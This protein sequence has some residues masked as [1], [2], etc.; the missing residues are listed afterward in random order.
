M[1]LMSR[2]PY[3]GNVGLDCC[4]HKWTW[5]NTAVLAAKADTILREI[6]RN[7]KWQAWN[8]AVTLQGRWGLV[9]MSLDDIKIH[10][11]ST[12]FFFS[13]ATNLVHS[14]SQPWL[15]LDQ[16][17]G[18]LE[19]KFVFCWFVFVYNWSDCL[20]WLN[21]SVRRRGAVRLPSLLLVSSWK[22]EAGCTAHF[23]KMF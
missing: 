2:N 16:L 21:G 13:A 23:Q 10:Q 15:Q 4:V 18:L 3:S 14:V 1:Q 20:C 7:T 8:L 22:G 19:G 6:S 17:T 11:C 5:V 12:K 9:R